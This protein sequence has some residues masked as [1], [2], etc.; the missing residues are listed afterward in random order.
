MK[1]PND[2]PFFQDIILIV[3]SVIVLHSV[4]TTTQILGKLT[5]CNGTRSR[6]PLILLRVCR[7]WDRLGRT[8]VVQTERDG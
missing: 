8:R 7:V 2:E 3:M 1:L 4:M 5:R 6:T